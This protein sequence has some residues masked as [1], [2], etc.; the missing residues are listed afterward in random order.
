MSGIGRTDPRNLDVLSLRPP[1]ETLRS[2]QSPTNMVFTIIISRVACG[3]HF[4]S[5]FFVHSTA[6]FGCSSFCL[7]LFSRPRN[8]TGQSGN[9]IAEMAQTLGYGRALGIRS[10]GR[11][12]RARLA[13]LTEERVEVVTSFSSTSLPASS[14]ASLARGTLGF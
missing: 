2:K 8:Q 11:S 9:A 14:F 7:F 5:D 1:S 10:P 13:I 6:A 3:Y 4:Y 12:T